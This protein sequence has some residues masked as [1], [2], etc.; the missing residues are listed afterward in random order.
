MLGKITLNYSPNFSTNK[1]NKK[2]IKLLIFHYTGMKNENKAISRLT[3]VNS[4]VSSHYFIKKNGQ[5]ILLVPELYVAWH[6]GKS[7][8]K[9][10]KSLNKSS[11]GIEIQNTGHQFGYHKFTNSQIK[12]LVK[13][14]IYLIKKYK[15]NNK[16]ILGHSDV[17]H[18]RKKDPGEKFP[19]QFLA[20]KKIGIWHNLEKIKLRKNRN[21]K[22]TIIGKKK[23]L[24]CLKK[25]GYFVRQIS[26]KQKKKLITAFQRRFRPELI[27][28]KIDKECLIIAQKISKLYNYF[29]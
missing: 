22:I 18:D 6:A 15:I 20:K 27:N 25:I 3:D 11:I 5:T 9:K 24:N 29:S 14:S 13:L 21:L 1:R 2:N 7:Y 19:W 26:L 17:A 12:S 16:N 4:K 10:Q 28:G 23:F 8:W